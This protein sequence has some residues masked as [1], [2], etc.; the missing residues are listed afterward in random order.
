M[1]SVIKTGGTAAG[2][3]QAV[4]S[5][6][7]CNSV[8]A[9]FS[10][11]P[12][13]KDIARKKRRVSMQNTGIQDPLNLNLYYNDVSRDIV[14]FANEMSDAN[15]SQ[16]KAW[17]ISLY[18]K[19][20]VIGTCLSLEEQKKILKKA[21]YS[22]KE[23]SA[24]RIHQIMVE[25]LES[26]NDISTRIDTYL[27][28]KFRREIS[29]YLHLE[30]SA[31]LKEWRDHFE[32]GLIEE[33]FWVAAIRS[34][35]SSSAILSIFGDIHMQM[36]LNSGKN[37][38]EKKHLTYQKEE[39]RK[40]GQRLKE[41]SQINRGIKKE[42]GRFEEE[43]TEL[44]RAC[45]SLQKERDGIRRDLNDLQ[46]RNVVDILRVENH[47][48]KNKIE[49]L[50]GVIKDYQQEIRSMEDLNAKLLSKIDRENEKDGHL[51]KEEEASMQQITD[52]NQSDDDPSA[53]YLGLKRVLIVGGMTKLETLY[54][55]LI[56]EK[57][58]IFE[59]HDGYMNGGSIGLE[60]KIRRADVVLCPVNC[61][62]HNACSMVK[63]F[64]KKYERHVYMLSNSSLSS[65]SQALFAYQRTLN[66]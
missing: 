33:I 36:H 64:S 49:E 65:I 55:K 57:E 5:G 61:N 17:K 1:G 6:S 12:D 42:R 13:Q 18:F 59:Y 15:R 41:A 35:L 7:W 47:K 56:E 10:L 40:L 25:S 34:D 39:N 62:S 20:P 14:R 22:T 46:G 48:L 11:Y 37:R 52:S 54:R 27:N 2:K 53:F 38:K 29:E 63:R 32:K 51:R 21:G 45:M 26:E 28:R 3:K 66:I 24:F 58:G 43:R 19:C 31:F 60:N 44:Q 9:A 30:E 50:S 23:L 16:Q 8:R 4:S